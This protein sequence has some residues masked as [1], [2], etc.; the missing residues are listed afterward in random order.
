MKKRKWMWILIFIFGL[1]WGLFPKP[2]NSE[3]EKTYYYKEYTLV[4]SCPSID[5]KPTG[6]LN[7]GDNIKSYHTLDE[8][9]EWIQLL[10]GGFINKKHLKE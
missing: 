8:L 6:Y 2:W 7:A 9:P 4:H 5:C 1:W 3:D 10:D